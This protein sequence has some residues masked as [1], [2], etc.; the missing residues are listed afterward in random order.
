MTIG[1]GGLI[2][3]GHVVLRSANQQSAVTTSRRDVAWFVLAVVVLI[4]SLYL[5][6]S[7]LCLRCTYIQSCLLILRAAVI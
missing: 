6:L 5:C 2:D 4:F 1:G 3:H 7:V